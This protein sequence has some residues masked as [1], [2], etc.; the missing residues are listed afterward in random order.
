MCVEMERGTPSMLPHRLTVLTGYCVLSFPLI[1]S[2]VH[3][4]FS[5]QTPKDLL[6]G[7]PAS[8]SRAHTREAS[9]IKAGLS[10]ENSNTKA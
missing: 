4:A 1:L 8:T 9:T 10:R 5:G 2:S 7:V 6:R 3:T